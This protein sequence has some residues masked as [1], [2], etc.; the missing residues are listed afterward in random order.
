MGGKVW[1]E[2]MWCREHQLAGDPM[3]DCE[4]CAH[5]FLFLNWMVVGARQFVK[6]LG[7]SRNNR[8]RRFR[9]G[10]VCGHHDVFGHDMVGYFFED[11]AFRA[12]HPIDESV[13]VRAAGFRCWHRL[14]KLCNSLC[15]PDVS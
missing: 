5:E 4:K 14:I 7:V 3:A 9:E 6:R 11:S 2:S 1:V 15:D 13:R 8:E 10:S 12:V